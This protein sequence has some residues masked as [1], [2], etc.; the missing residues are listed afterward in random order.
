M[1]DAPDPRRC[2]YCSDPLTSAAPPVSVATGEAHCGANPYGDQHVPE[3]RDPNCWTCMD[4]GEIEVCHP[5]FDYV[6]R[7]APCPA[8]DD[9]ECHPPRPPAPPTP[10]SLIK[11]HSCTDYRCCPPF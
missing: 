6:M 9:P 4:S 7:W 1:T 5:S 10:V 8:L 3:P 2:E 11:P